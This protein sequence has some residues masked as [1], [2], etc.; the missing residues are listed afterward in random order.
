MN[1]LEMQKP[2]KCA[3]LLILLAAAFL[4][5]KY[6]LQISP[7]VIAHDL[8]QSYQLTA[9]A[10]GFMVGF[11]FYTYLIMQIPSGILLD[12]YGIEKIGPLAILICAL[13]ALLFS[14]TTSFGLA[15]LAR[16]MIGFG[17]AF[18]TLTYFKIAASYFPPRYFPMFSGLFGTACMTGA[19]TAGAPLAV[20]VNHVGWRTTILLCGLIGLLL[21]LLFWRAL[22]SPRLQ[23]V[24][25]TEMQPFTWQA[26]M[27]ILKNKLNWPLIWYGG[28]A[29]TP[30]SV[31][32][33]LWGAPFLMAAYHLPRVAA[34]SSISLVFFGFAIGGLIIGYLGQRR[35]KKLPVVVLATSLELIFLAIVIYLPYLPIW[36]LNACIFGFGFCASGFL[37]SY[38]I[39]KNLNPVSLV[40]TVI[41]I[42]NMSD[43]L[44][45][46]VTEPLIG[47]ILDVQW[48]GEM[49]DQVRVFSVTAYQWGLSVLVLLLF[50]A[51]VCC[52]FIN[53]SS[54]KLETNL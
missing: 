6:I 5:Y 3:W 25:V 10:L 42:I 47:K 20:L 7:A 41:G 40:G 12:H 54:G 34:G 32:G 24:A 8:M 30:V 21:A 14:Q 26:F 2:T 33:G 51:L 23:P 39:A 9:T 38:D 27:G 45:G 13:G 19:G 15:C 11:Y 17:G 1:L 16:L 52:Y 49:V 4:F 46:G 18:A 44:C 50:L 37:L 22:K 48:Q 28:L 29:F 43:P 31:F 36:L 53:E 35:Q